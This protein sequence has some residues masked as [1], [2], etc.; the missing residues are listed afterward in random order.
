MNSYLPIL[1][2]VGVSV[3]IS[4]AMVVGS[5]LLGP[6]KPSAAKSS[7]YECGMVP[8]GNARERFPI[9]FYLIAMLFIIFDVETIFLYPF[10]V[11]YRDQAYS[12]KVFYLTEMAVFSAILFV[13][14]F[15][16]LGKGALDWDESEQA[17]S[18]DILTPEVLASRPPLR[19]GNENSGEV[20]LGLMKQGERAPVFG[21]SSQEERLPGREAPVGAREE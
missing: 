16:I 8:V 3:L 12:M 2:M 18:T 14:Y 1:V 9:K 20:D 11:A 17:R 13:G 7:P 6:K 15:Y 21:A 19:F 5:F 4:V 10:A